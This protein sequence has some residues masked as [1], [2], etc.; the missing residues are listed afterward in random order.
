M[1]FNEILKAIDN[2]DKFDIAFDNRYR[3]VARS[4][5]PI[6]LPINGLFNTEPFQHID[7]ITINKTDV[8]NIISMLNEAIDKLKSGTRKDDDVEVFGDRAISYE[9]LFD[10][11]GYVD[12]T[13]PAD[14]E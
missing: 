9:R 14:N 4:K 3:L 1:E 6:E 11:M 12:Y 5:D 2:S 13:I 10:Y 7:Y 8:D